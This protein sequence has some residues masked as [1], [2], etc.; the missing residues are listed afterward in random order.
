MYSFLDPAFVSLHPFPSTPITQLHSDPNNTSGSA[1]DATKTQCGVRGTRDNWIFRFHQLSQDEEDISMTE[2]SERLFSSNCKIDRN[3]RI[4][5]LFWVCKYLPS[6]SSALSILREYS[7][8]N[9]LFFSLD[10]TERSRS[11]DRREFIRKLPHLD[12]GI[13]LDTIEM[14][15][16]AVKQ[17][18]S[19][20]ICRCVSFENYLLNDTRQ[21]T[22]SL[23][24]NISG[25]KST[26][27]SALSH[28]IN[29]VTLLDTLS[30]SKSLS[31]NSF[32]DVVNLS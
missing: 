1:M 6:K 10:L 25:P 7:S 31:L 17:F 8:D 27:R 14:K 22:R 28:S 23:K 24:T 2:F 32:F 18:W 30:S 29:D 9:R 26:H 16:N 20:I 19:D 15:I 4:V 11:K 5:F 21:V 12:K 3:D 13:R